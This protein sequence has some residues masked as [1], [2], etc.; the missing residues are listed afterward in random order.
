MVVATRGFPGRIRGSIRRRR[1]CRHCQRFDSQKA[2]EKGK[3]LD[4][5]KLI[6]DITRQNKPALA[7]PGADEII[8]HLAPQ[9]RTGDVVA[10]M[11]NGGF[12]GIH[13]RLLARLGDSE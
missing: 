11:S 6:N 10:I 13:D 4:T 2:L 5:E 3:T 9:L 1:L 8:D 12:G 7:L